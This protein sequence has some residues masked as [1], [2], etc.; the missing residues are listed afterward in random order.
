MRENEP[1]PALAQ[2]IVAGIRA[3]GYPHVAAEARGVSRKLFERWLR[4]GGRKNAPEPFAG[5]AVEVRSA[6][7]QARLRAE[8]H[9]LDEAPRV[10]L[11]HG[12]GREGPGN[13]GWS[14]SVKATD[15][16]T[17]QQQNP[18]LDERFLAHCRSMREALAPYPEAH[19]ALMAAMAAMGK[20]SKNRDDPGEPPALPAF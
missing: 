16:A 15:M 11:E 2:Q 5:F 10:W 6:A 1:T 13:A 8:M 4:L 14:G 20:R 17:G 12:P 18:L 9:I 3:G 7:A 19:A